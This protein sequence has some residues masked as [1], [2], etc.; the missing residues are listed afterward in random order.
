MT[1]PRFEDITEES[2]DNKRNDKLR[3]SIK[4]NE[5]KENQKKE[6]QPESKKGKKSI[7]VFAILRVLYNTLYYLLV[8]TLISLFVFNHFVWNTETPFIAGNNHLQGLFN[9]DKVVRTI[10]IVLGLAYSPRITIAYLYLFDSQLLTE[11][12]S[13]SGFDTYQ[14]L[15]SSLFENVVKLTG[16]ICSPRLLFLYQT[17]NLIFNRHYS[18]VTK[19]GLFKVVGDWRSFA[20]FTEYLSNSFWKNDSN[21]E[22][23]FVI[24]TFIV[25]LLFILYDFKTRIIMLKRSIKFIIMLG[26][27]IVLNAYF[28]PPIVLIY[29]FKVTYFVQPFLL[30]L[31]FG[32][33][34]F[35]IAYENKL[36]EEQAKHQQ[37]AQKKEQ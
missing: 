27:W 9:E 32:V 18:S 15:S 5:K 19:D 21:F 13:Q 23:V 14:F 26:L 8:I 36:L 12:F 33:E 30:A 28:L 29:M 11:F 37:A 20:E 24:F 3:S 2:T 34:K 31:M 17:G 6:K 22:N 1:E 35:E 25:Q 16:W 4:R 10:N 7:S